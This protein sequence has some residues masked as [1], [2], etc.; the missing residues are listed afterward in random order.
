MIAEVPDEGPGR[1]PL[2]VER[3]RRSLPVGAHVKGVPELDATVQGLEDGGKVLRN[4]RGHPVAVGVDL[5]I[6]K[7]A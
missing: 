2:E 7:G 5:A 6:Q 1:V 3:R 4:D